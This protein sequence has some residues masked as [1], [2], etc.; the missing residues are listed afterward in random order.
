MRPASIAVAV[1][2]LWFVIGVAPVSATQTVIVSNG[3]ASSAASFTA[4]PSGALT[5]APGSPFSTGAG[6]A[7]VAFTPDAR[8]AYVA[9]VT[10]DDIARFSVG[11]DSQLT[12]LGTTPAGGNNPTGLTV[13]PD[14]SLL[15][16]TDR[17]GTDT[18]PRVSVF[19][20]DAASGGLTAVSGSPFNVGNFQPSAVAI[21][22]DGKFAYVSGRRGPLGPPA[23][24][25]NSALAVASIGSTG[26]LT[27]IGGSPFYD[28]TVLGGF[29]LG[30]SPDG[31]RL[32][33]T[34]PNNNKLA[35]YNLDKTTGVPT[36]AVGPF[37][38][39][40]TAPIEVEPTP[41]GRRLYVTE[42]F[43]QA[44][45]GFSINQTTGALTSIAGTPEPAGAQAQGLGI[46]ADG[47]TLFASRITNPGTVRAFAIA[48]ATGDLTP[49]G[50]PVETGDAFPSFF[51]VA[52]SPTQT[53][54]VSFDHSDA[55][56]GEPT[57]F[58]STTTVRG[59]YATR[60][61]WDFGDG[62]TLADAGPTATHT[63]TGS[64]PHTVTLTV[65]NDCDPAAVYSG[66]VVTVGTRVVCNGPRSAST[67]V[68]VDQAVVL[69]AKAKS[70]QPAGKVAVTLTCPEEACTVALSGRTKGKS[71]RK[72]SSFALKGK[73]VEVPAG[74]PTKVKLKYAKGKRAVRKLKRLVSTGRLKT[75]VVAT[76]EDAAG[77]EVT[78]QLKVKGKRKKR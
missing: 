3:S 73:S 35:V 44:V 40:A 56:P 4:S 25:A 33:E 48:A 76:A 9:S 8:F 18:A 64:K 34:L 61:D 75:S 22:P 36:V 17:D 41:D 74:Q 5:A 27:P 14:G 78:R 63:F 66:N 23:S 65:A 38:T 70:K 13:S 26:A 46:A 55:K 50:S 53:P 12:S 45:E 52:V 28:A 60:F 47:Q 11:D 71:G 1:I 39:G 16:V 58:T 32:F 7:A 77:N 59:G 21:S 19:R 68:T 20:I 10:D 67:S 42:V 31:S 37:T 54:A 15:M 51:S 6:P 43:G 62:T 72:R 69:D 2:A 49:I 24:N 30:I 57:S 29:D